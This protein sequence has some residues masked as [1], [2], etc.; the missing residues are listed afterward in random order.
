MRLNEALG[1]TW[2]AMEEGVFFMRCQAWPRPLRPFS[3]GPPPSLRTGL[4][5]ASVPSRMPGWDLHRKGI[6]GRSF[7]CLTM[8]NGCLTPLGSTANS[9]DVQAY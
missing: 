2:E 3:A 6:T 1:W 5:T 4:P 9:S 8:F 7:L